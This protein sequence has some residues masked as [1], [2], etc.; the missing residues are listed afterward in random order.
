MSQNKKAPT[1]GS[2]LF[3]SFVLEATIACRR[4]PFEHVDKKGLV[5]AG[6]LFLFLAFLLK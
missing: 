2:G 6:L 5:L 4:V 1:E 3:H